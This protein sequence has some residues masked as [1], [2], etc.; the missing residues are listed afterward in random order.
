MSLSMSAFGAR[1]ETF[2]EMKKSLHLP[3]DFLTAA[4]GFNQLMIELSVSK[5]ILLQFV[6]SI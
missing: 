6:T 3:N 4:R 2:K 5:K 1:N